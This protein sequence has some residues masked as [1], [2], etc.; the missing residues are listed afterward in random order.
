MTPFCQLSIISSKYILKSVD[1]RGQPWH[2]PLLI[3]ASFDSMELNFINILFYVF[4]S[5]IAFINVSRIFLDFKISQSVFVYYQM[6][7]YNL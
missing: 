3:S 2:T 6:L 1:E 7:S 4:I 5:S